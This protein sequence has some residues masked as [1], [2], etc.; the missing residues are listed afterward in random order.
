MDL[1]KVA[2]ETKACN[3]CGKIKELSKFTKSKQ[4]KSGYTCICKECANA[5]MQIWR[6]KNRGHVKN[7]NTLQKKLKRLEN[8]EVYHKYNKDYYD[9]HKDIEI[10][11]ST[12]YQINNKDKVNK[13]RRKRHK[14]R[15]ETDIIYRICFTT[16]NR[17]KSFLKI[18]TINKQNK[19]FDIIGCS[20]EYL[21][22]YLETQFK[23]GM[24]WDNYG[25]KG[26]HVDH[27]IPLSSAKNED[28]IYKLAH[29][30]NLQPLWADE[31]YNK[32]VKILIND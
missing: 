9:S 31:N 22:F 14:E 24:S 2:E 18:K 26:W 29:Y 20:S 23:D 30:T 32:G 5:K 28:E 1:N 25:L 7:L 15:Y 8:P 21:K 13:T 19:T 4:Y 17:L 10:K 16:R 11:R 27:K 3:K 12:D 6:D